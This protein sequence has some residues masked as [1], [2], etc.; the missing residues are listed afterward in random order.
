MKKLLLIPLAAI[1]LILPGCAKPVL[2]GTPDEIVAQMYDH[3]NENVTVRVSADYWSGSIDPDF[4]E[5]VI[6]TVYEAP[7]EEMYF[8]FELPSANFE[9]DVVSKHAEG[10]VYVTDT[11]IEN[12]KQ[13]GWLQFFGAKFAN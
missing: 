1:M 10:T 2:E 6:L 12:G 3:L 5:E 7:D 13:K 9:N 11:F 4:N 8:V